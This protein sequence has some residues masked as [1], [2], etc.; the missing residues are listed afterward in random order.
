M[1]QRQSNVTLA[2]ADLP[3]TRDFYVDGLA[4]E[5]ALDI[6]GEV[7]MFP[8]AEKVV[9]SLWAVEAFQA[10]TGVRPATSGTAPVT[11][12]HNCATPAGVDRVLEQA[13]HAGARSVRE[14]VQR[15][16]GGYSG[17]FTDPDG[18]LWEVAYNPGEIGRSVL[19]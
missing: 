13:R 2:V 3:A 5:P 17:Y 8:V 6:P 9:L 11:L 16:W 7:L 19:P 14:A 10:E 4:W 1:D 18:F 12:A 15:E